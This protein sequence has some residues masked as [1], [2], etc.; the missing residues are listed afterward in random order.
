[1]RKKL[2]T[3]AM[4]FLTVGMLL[5][6][7]TARAEG[8]A[9]FSNGEHVEPADCETKCCAKSCNACAT[10]GHYFCGPLGET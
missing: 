3:C 1:M 8:G 10:D 5:M 9:C 7:S 6:P 2:W 4:S